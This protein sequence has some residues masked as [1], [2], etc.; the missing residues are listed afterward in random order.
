MSVKLSVISPTYN[1]AA[2][3]EALVTGIHRALDGRG[4]EF[5]IIIADDDSPDGTWQRVETMATHDPRVSVLRRS[6]NRGLGPAVVDGFLRARGDYVACIDADLQHDPAALP[7]ML[8]E[9]EGGA[10][11]AVGTRY[12][13]GATTGDWG[14]LRRMESRVATKLTTWS[15]GVRLN[16]PLS[17][18]FMLRRAD[19]LRVKDRLN[20]TGFKILLDIAATLQPA[21]VAEVPYAFRARTAGESKVSAGIVSAYLRQLWKLSWRERG[22]RR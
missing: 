10:D 5:E 6:G 21:R 12:M 7:T 3:V 9:L 16:D 8:Q 17:G 2:N 4:Y 1:E 14:R 13:P 22:G 15:T 19:F 18:Y 11:L 20:T